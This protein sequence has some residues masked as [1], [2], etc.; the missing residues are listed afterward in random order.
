MNKCKLLVLLIIFSFLTSGYTKF[1][2]FKY[3]DYNQIYKGFISKND[4]IQPKIELQSMSS[5]VTCSGNPQINDISFLNYI[6]PSSNGIYGKAYLTCTDG[7]N[8]Y[9]YLKTKGFYLNKISGVGTD[10]YERKLSFYIDKNA[11]NVNS[12]FDKYK[13]EQAFRCQLPK[14]ESKIDNSKG[15]NSKQTLN[16]SDFSFYVRNLE[17]TIKSNWYPS[18]NDKSR[19]VELMFKVSKNGELLNYKIFKPSGDAGWDN[20]A[21]DALKA[22]LPLPPLPKAF[23]GNS[24][25]IKFTF[26]CHIANQA[27]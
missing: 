26:V 15:N 10:M 1:I 12:V 9:V 27:F 18:Y 21:L 19:K 17:R 8:L 6:N 7:S 16:T 24:I 14:L 23:S 11:Q 25:D 3:D 22:S 4:S 2:V 13:Y 5:D 20:A